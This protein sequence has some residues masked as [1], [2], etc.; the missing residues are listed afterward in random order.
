[1]CRYLLPVSRDFALPVNSRRVKNPGILL[2]LIFE[3]YGK[4][5]YSWWKRRTLTRQIIQVSVHHPLLVIHQTFPM[6]SVVALLAG[7]VSTCFHPIT[8]QF[9][10]VGQEFMKCSYASSCNSK[11]RIF[12]WNNFFGWK[13]LRREYYWNRYGTYVVMLCYIVQEISLICK[14]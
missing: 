1:M 2:C 5:T 8:H 14:L 7:L 12:V 10:D 9:K 4:N 3:A 6:C 13:F 11:R